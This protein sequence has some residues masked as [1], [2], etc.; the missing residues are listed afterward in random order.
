MT[1]ST[2]EKFTKIFNFTQP[3]CT[4]IFLPQVMPKAAICS[5]HFKKLV[6]LLFFSSNRYANNQAIHIILYGLLLYLSVHCTFAPNKVAQ[7]A[8]C[9]IKI[10]YMAQI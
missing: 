5:I 10:F 1:P 6:I 2:S 8:F 7:I 4:L 3:Q 9:D